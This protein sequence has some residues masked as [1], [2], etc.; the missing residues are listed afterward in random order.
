M[1][2][3][4][5]LLY[6]HHHV[7]NAF[8]QEFFGSII[9]C[10]IIDILH[11]WA[12]PSLGLKTDAIPVAINQILLC[13]PWLQRIE[14]NVGWSSAWEKVRVSGAVYCKLDYVASLKKTLPA[15]DHRGEIID[16][17]EQTLLEGFLKSL[18]EGKHIPERIR[19]L[20]WDFS[21]EKAHRSSNIGNILGT[22]STCIYW[23]A[24]FYVTNSSKA[25]RKIQK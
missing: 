5:S 6:V 16:P 2:G 7:S 13:G 10:G 21:Y 20:A 9:I 24:V 17:Q 19:T 12:V 23:A 22:S 15:H 3:S 1:S 14:L 25:L 18:E 8:R 4:T 11:S